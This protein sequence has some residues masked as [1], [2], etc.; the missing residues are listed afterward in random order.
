MELNVIIK[1]LD[2][3]RKAR[4]HGI[5]LQPTLN[6]GSLITCNGRTG[7]KKYTRR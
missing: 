5:K 6:L 4:H 1:K 3:I 2:V 7:R